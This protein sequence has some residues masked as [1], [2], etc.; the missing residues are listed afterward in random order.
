MCRLNVLWLFGH[1][2]L[3]PAG[4]RSA[5]TVC[6]QNIVCGYIKYDNDRNNCSALL[7]SFNC[8]SKIS[9]PCSISSE[10]Q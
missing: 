1:H 8:I 4:A 5:M 9:N 2:D 10:V 6:Q 7:G 3:A